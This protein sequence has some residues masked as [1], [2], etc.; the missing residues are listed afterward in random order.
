MEILLAHIYKIL[1]AYSLYVCVLNTLVF[2][3]LE[4]KK[5]LHPFMTTIKQMKAACCTTSSSCKDKEWVQVV[6]VAGNSSNNNK[7]SPNITKI[8]N[9]EK[10]NHPGSF[11]TIDHLLRWLVIALWAIIEFTLHTYVHICNLFTFPYVLHIPV[12]IL[13]LLWNIW[14]F[15]LRSRMTAL[16]SEN[17]NH[18]K[19]LWCVTI[20]NKFS[21]YLVTSCA[22]IVFL[23]SPTITKSFSNH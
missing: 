1:L 2:V 17:G 12:N 8:E 7:K 6:K 15:I 4:R 22:I 19:G 11:I 16:I 14:R 3:C 18:R 13:I 23:P 10:E 21:I 9:N 20:C 5:I